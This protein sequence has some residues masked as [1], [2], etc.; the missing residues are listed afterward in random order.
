MDLQQILAILQD[1]TQSNTLTLQPDALQSPPI[2]A[3]FRDYLLD[4]P[5]VIQQVS[6]VPVGNQNITVVGQGSSFPF[7]NTYV[8]AV[9]TAPNGVAAMNIEADGFANQAEVWDFAKAFPVLADTF[10]KE[11]KF[12]TAKFTL[13]SSNASATQPAGLVFEGQQEFVG[14]LAVINQ[15]L[16]SSNLA[17]VSGSIRLFGDKTSESAVP[18]MVLQDSTAGDEFG[19]QFIYEL[20]DEVTITE[21]RETGARNT[22]PVPEMRLISQISVTT[23]QGPEVL[24]VIA[25]F[26]PD[27]G[28]LVFQADMQQAVLVLSQVALNALAGNKNLAV[29]LPPQLPLVNRFELGQWSMAVAPDVPQ[30]TSLEIG[31]GIAQPW[32]IIPGWFTLQ[33][34]NFVYALNYINDK[35]E[36]NASLTAKITLL[37]GPAQFTI[38]VDAQYPSYVIN[39]SLEEGTEVDL[40]ALVRFFLGNTIA[41]SLP[42]SDLRVV[43]M[44]LL[45]DPRNT[46][47][48]FETIIESDCSF[49]L[50]GIL[51]TI[52]QITFTFNYVASAATGSFGAQFWILPP[53]TS[54]AGLLEDV[55]A[56][57]VEM[58]VVAAYNGA[59]DGWSFRGGLAE[60]GQIDLTTLVARYLPPQFGIFLPTVVITQLEAGFETGASQA[61]DF[62]IGADWTIALLNTKIS[63]LVKVSARTVDGKRRNEGEI[64]G[65][66][67]FGGD[68]DEGGLEFR[69]TANFDEVRKIYKFYFLGWEATLY[70]E[71]EVKTLTFNARS[72]SLGEM[73]EV[74]INAV[75]PG[76]DIK[77]TSPWSVLN[78]VSLDTFNFV[79]EF[80]DDG[81]PVKAGFTYEPRVN[82]GFARLD[83]IG[84]DYEVTTGR[85]MFQILQGSFLGKEI[86]PQNKVEWNVAEPETTPAVPGQGSEL[87]RLD[88]LGLGQHMG[89]FDEKTQ[90]LAP[91]PASIFGAI[92]QLTDAFENK[93]DLSLAF[94]EASGWLI[95][96]RF[97]VI[98]AID[99]GAVFYDPELF[100]I[101]VSVTG[102]KSKEKLPIFDGLVFEV[103][104]KK[105]N[106]TIGMWQIDLTLPYYIR[107]LEFGAVSVTLP[108]MKLQIYTNGDFLVDFGF[109]TN[110]DFSRSF[111]IQAFPF[112]GSGGVYFGVLSSAT[113]DRVPQVTD[114]SFSPVIAFGLGLRIG[115][116]KDVKYGPLKAGLSVTV[117]GVLEGLFAWYNRYPTAL[118]EGSSGNAQ[119]TVAGSRQI[120]GRRSRQLSASS[121]SSDFYYMIQARVALVGKMYGTVDLKI[122]T[123]QLDVE[124]RV[125]IRLTLEAYRAIDI[126][127]EVTVSL[128]LRVK[129]NLGLFKVTIR[130]TFRMKLSFSFTIGSNSTPPWG[131]PTLLRG[132]SFVRR[133]DA[134]DDE[135]CPTIP[136]MKWQ[137]LINPNR[138]HVPLFFVPQFTAGTDGPV[139]VPNP[140]K[141]YVVAMTYVPS[142]PVQSGTIAPFDEVA[143]GAFFW[144][145]NAYLNRDK[146]NTTLPEL[147]EQ[148]VTI[149][150]L[151]EINCYLTQDDFM[152]PFTEAELMAFLQ[153][154]FTFTVKLPDNA[155]EID[156]SVFPIMPLLQLT[157]STG[158]DVDFTTQT[159]ASEEYLASI[160]AYFEELAVRYKS[161]SEKA[162]EGQEALSESPDEARK[163]LAS[164]IFLDF[165][166][167]L[168]RSTIQDAI[169]V[170][171]QQEAPVEPNES[172]ADFVERRT[173]LAIDVVSLVMANPT[174]PLRAGVQLRVPGVVYTIKRGDT[175]QSIAAMFN[176]D[177]VELRAAN[178]FIGNR[179][180]P[181]ASLRLPTLTFTT[182]TTEP[183]SLLDIS[184]LYGVSLANLAQENEDVPELFPAGESLLA[185]FAQQDTVFKLATRLLENGSFTN[186]SGLA[187]RVLLQGLRPPSPPDSPQAGATA[188][189][190]E[191]TGQQFDG[192]GL[193]AGSTITLTAPAAI[194]PWFNL[195]SNN[196]VTYTVTAQTAS[197]LTRLTTAAFDPIAKFEPAQLLNIEPRRFTLANST[198][199]HTPK[200]VTSANRGTE[201]VGAAIEPQLWQFPS[202]LMEVITGPQALQPK[203]DLWT[204]R[205]EAPGQTYPRR[206]VKQYTWATTIEIQVRQ[207]PSGDAVFLP[208]VYE[209][210]G[211]DSGAS[212][213]LENLLVQSAR[214]KPPLIFELQVLYPPNPTVPNEPEPPTGLRS[215]ADPTFFL[216]QTNL[217]TASQP[218]QLTAELSSQLAAATTQKAPLGQ[219][220]LEFLKLLW[221]SSVVNTGGYVLYY[222]AERTNGLPS[223]LFSEDGI[224]TVTLL[225][226]YSIEGNVLQN[227]L[228]TVVIHEAIDTENEVLYAAPVTQTVSN[229][230]LA[231]DQSLADVAARYRVTV[232]DLATQYNN[233]QTRLTVGKHL[234][235]PPLTYRVLPGDELETI[236]TRANVAPQAIAEL[237][238]H[239]NATELSSVRFLRIPE[240]IWRVVPGDTLESLAERF[241]VTVITLA[242]ANKT[243]AG[244]FEESI[245]FDDRL[246]EPIATIP[247]GN[248]AFTLRRAPVLTNSTV[249]DERDQLEE[250]YNLLDYRI[251]PG[252]GFEGTNSAL[253]ISPETSEE[254]KEWIYNSVVPVFPFVT[255][256]P[257]SSD[258]VPDPKMDPYNGVGSTVEL[259]FYW[260][261][262]FGN[263]LDTG[264]NDQ[265]WPDRGF[266][267]AY[268]DHLI[269]M[270]QW[271]SVTSDYTIA[272]N[273]QGNPELTVTL[274]FNAAI[275]L[276]EDDPETGQETALTDLGKFQIV[277][278]QLTQP[279][280]TVTL[281]SSMQPSGPG[282]E[283][284]SP[285]EVM[286]Q[287]VLSVINF[288]KAVSEGQP[289]PT[290][291]ADLSMSQAVADQNP[292]NLFAL[293]V[294]LQINRNPD[295]VNDEFKD[296]ASVS[297]VSSS[298][299]ANA[300]NN[301]EATLQSEPVPPLSLQEFA[302]QL[303]TA[304]PALKVLVAAPKKALG[305]TD[306]EIWIARLAPTT[307]GIAFNI[308]GQ[309]P[310]FFAVPPLSRNLLSRPDVLVYPYHPGTFI[311]NESP[312]KT[313]QNSVD[314]DQLGRD[315]LTAV[316]EVLGPQFSAETWKLEYEFGDRSPSDPPD[317]QKNPYE[318][319]IWAKELLANAIS[320]QVVTIFEGASLDGIEAAREQLRQ[321][322]LVALTAAYTIDVVMQYPVEVTHSQY[323]ADDAFAPQM[324]GKPVADNPDDPEAVERK[325]AFSFSTGKFSL[326]KRA[327]GTHLTF[328][329]D[330][331]QEQ[332]GRTGNQFE[333]V[334]TIDLY[335][336]LNALEHEIHPVEGIEGYLASSWLTFV[337]PDNFDTP[338]ERK[339]LV[340]LGTQ[341]IPVPLRAFPTPPSLSEQ[342]FIPLVKQVGAD[343]E[344]SG[345]ELLRQARL[346]KYACHYEYVGAAHDKILA[347]IKLNVPS[348][349]FVQATF[350]DADNPDLFAA[351][352]QFMAVYPEIANDLDE[353]LATGTDRKVAENAIASFAWL[354]QRAAIAWAAW[355]SE[356]VL[357][358]VVDQNSPEY[359]FVIVQRAEEINGVSALVVSVIADGALR[360]PKLP[361]VEI[362]GYRTEPRTIPQTDPSESVSYYFVSDQTQQILTYN[363]G[364]DL[365][366]RSLVFDYFDVL[367]VENAWAG[368]AV[369]RNEDLVPGEITNP[370]FVLQSPVVRFIN[371]LTPLLD[372]DVEINMAD[373]TTP[374]PARLANFLSNFLIAFFEGAQT[375]LNEKRTILMNAY[376]SYGFDPGAS[377]VPDLNVMIPVLLTLPTSISILPQNLSPESPFVSSV[378]EVINQWF[379][380]NSPIG[381]DGNGKLWFDLSV[382]SSLSESQLP[383]L[384]MR[385]LFLET[386]KIIRP[387]S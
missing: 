106:D 365:S 107:N 196:S 242:H 357:H 223:Y 249:I 264:R 17:T 159:P 368:A 177:V 148:F 144:T 68:D 203:V 341:T 76:D 253:P 372:P 84:L 337:L 215:D 252:N 83:K 227:Y 82:L 49:S 198:L 78:S 174:R 151:N 213:L 187:A 130:L 232:S 214:S 260:Q 276:P 36:P 285:R 319:I 1:S 315:F 86:N 128:S 189:L 303:Q 345:E 239:V 375:V 376:Y 343:S 19:M 186:L 212:R 24:E 243:V 156:V 141:P 263:W 2:A 310:T 286:V 328:S 58:E 371:V 42:C 113:T 317:P 217:S 89:V 299:P 103:L 379:A 199:W 311:G 240:T 97:T 323:A 262:L 93:N 146:V 18:E 80:A 246:L 358:D 168:A 279:D 26:T 39:G 30:I 41:S 120:T 119:M 353:Y 332:Q 54:A 381:L 4:A 129:I 38:D 259:N 320:D 176:A 15:I 140:R 195:G 360:L 334:F 79:V 96:T 331:N 367:K 185:P 124:I 166:A 216:L 175:L 202:E 40:I 22:V 46:T 43:T 330:T 53:Q 312:I 290:P 300:G 81:A 6:I 121:G 326:A 329:F 297:V 302:L 47:F 352:V 12:V 29:L 235:I 204:Q 132:S 182:S 247:P 231:P 301:S 248:V 88:F 206:L 69:V 316:E 164:F 318:S 28:L 71:A 382:Y 346:W 333:D 110:E 77:L 294:R 271:P 233:A 228:N 31:A 342:A 64:E 136:V 70:Y 179:L 184:R 383:V 226:N 169:D 207:T 63:A 158:V 289:S 123:A 163:S 275:Y 160:K 194:N 34:I 307:T 336:Q 369:K 91:V 386:R 218:P 27:V 377:Q 21:N 278:Y 134:S 108:S 62:S 359:H 351:L 220:Y 94:N 135:A 137:P 361:V 102:S 131:Q 67:R 73:I 374:Q 347:S 370:A 201:Q 273:A 13:L 338:G 167:L 277:Y 236:A 122:I 238:P 380:Q 254:T 355:R 143:A 281:S 172:L 9:F 170:L 114:G 209:L 50:G 153:N 85:V 270:D 161:P 291:P 145:L 348:S 56:G 183:E 308:D 373:F 274:R 280:V 52:T 117:Q 20:L 385:R 139:G 261:D 257:D 241:S 282:A 98:Q 339:L 104:Y 268:I 16:K 197:M 237:N 59:E 335:H 154:Y 324:F 309:N 125:S 90:R 267:V 269:A 387:T 173:D 314:L 109:P 105:I 313:S 298:V 118:T 10:F 222:D 61:F 5:L 35:Y 7:P 193:G 225:I 152:E 165:F 95:G 354:A 210:T 171:Q 133:L 321:Q 72:K 45:L 245:E 265:Y 74:L 208:H 384:R 344:V 100:G 325:D 32:T 37:E 162:G 200:L 349:S 296:V 190:Y 292:Q 51:F 116:G 258:S 181:A 304:F 255:L 205:Q 251:K 272:R 65:I 66:F 244:V 229:F 147:L 191:L 178:S 305:Q 87:F 219:N 157:T 378:S 126:Y 48:T 340:P 350:N 138:V 75:L 287:F 99:L 44:T 284:A 155:N 295:L 266:S 25:H 256:T 230:K 356:S 11:L 283:S 23:E 362:A 127:F 363:D 322:L 149:D 142:V 288:L 366:T 327:T 92:T 364:R 221:E 115:L 211:I 150:Q 224:A 57:A 234:R 306:E 3:A 293:V 55:P 8:N 33:Q 111:S 14:H 60:G 180:E 192:T 250:L 112:V 101:V 188:P